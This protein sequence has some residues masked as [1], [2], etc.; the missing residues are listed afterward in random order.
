M[1]VNHPPT[2][3]EPACRGVTLH[4][5]DAWEPMTRA[6]ALAAATLSYIEPHVQPGISTA[7][8]DRLCHDFIR[9][10]GGIPASLGYRGFPG[11][12]CTSVNAVICH[13]VP[14]T[15]EY[16]DEG[17]ILNIDVAVRL[18]GW[19]GDT[20][21]MYAVGS[22][23]RSEALNLIEAT[24]QALKHGMDMIE[25]GITLGDVGHAIETY[26]KTTGFALARQ[27]CGHG[28]GTVFHGPPVV[29]HFGAPGIGIILREGMF[30]TLEPI[31]CSGEIA[32]QVLNDGW[33]TINPAGHLSAQ[34]EHTIGICSNGITV[35]TDP[36][37][38]QAQ[39][40]LNDMEG[41]QRS[42]KS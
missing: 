10:H 32:A 27:Y 37:A 41:S 21:R 23:H 1:R 42:L 29:P 17:D 20:S 19:H 13:G 5:S 4:S 15:D 16:L 7:T 22:A 38:K 28:I 25:P 2:P 26:T 3:I 12:I 31:L 14:R 18:D 30:L 34:F 39:L 6:G 8:L 40:L 33:T 9:N 11:S 35:F 24:R 36:Q